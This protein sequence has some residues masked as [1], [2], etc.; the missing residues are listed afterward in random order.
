[1]IV[2]SKTVVLEL[3]PGTLFGSVF[4]SDLRMD[5]SAL[6]FLSQPHPSWLGIPEVRLLLREGLV[7]LLL[8][9]HGAQG[10]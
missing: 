2:S 6:E 1:M 7:S 8:V 5:R 3:T 4:P 10:L 9:S